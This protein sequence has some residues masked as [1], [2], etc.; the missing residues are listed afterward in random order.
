VGTD[1]AQP[2]RPK[3][4]ADAENVIRR[5]AIEPEADVK[6]DLVMVVDAITAA[7]IDQ[8]AVTADAWKT[9]DIFHEGERTLGDFL[10]AASAGRRASMASEELS[11]QHAQ[12]PI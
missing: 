6:I 11:S 2:K 5:I 8:L 4:I 7:G 12:S 3:R 10:C 9:A 1:V